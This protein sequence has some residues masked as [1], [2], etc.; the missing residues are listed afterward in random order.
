[1]EG[2]NEKQRKGIILP[3]ITIFF[4]MIILSMAGIIRIR[5]KSEKV[6][7]PIDS[8]NIGYQDA[9]LYITESQIISMLSGGN[10][11]TGNLHKKAGT[12]AIYTGCLKKYLNGSGLRISAYTYEQIKKRIVELIDVMNIEHKSDFTKM[13]LDGRAVAIDIAGEIY[14]LCGLEMLMN[15]DG[16]IQQVKDPGG[17]V[18]YQIDNNATVYNFQVDIFAIALSILFILFCFILLVVKKNNLF[19][20]EVNFNEFDEK[21]FA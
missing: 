14:K 2:S 9:K 3:L 4:L 5:V 13:S 15:S 17:N 11:E 21:R 6:D 10:E 1:M 16:S 19:Q 20:K 7:L 8:S 12:F 18:I